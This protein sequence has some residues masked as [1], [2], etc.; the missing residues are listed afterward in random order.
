MSR[1]RE[2]GSWPEEITAQVM[3][4]SQ[5]LEGRQNGAAN[6]RLHLLGVFE[7][8]SFLALVRRQQGPRR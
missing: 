8:E 6:N 2:G 1:R 4:P 7:D 5:H 3:G